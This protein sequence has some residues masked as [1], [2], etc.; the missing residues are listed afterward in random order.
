MKYSH[1]GWIHA[2]TIARVAD[3]LWW[4]GKSLATVNATE[5]IANLIFTYAGVYNTCYCDSNVFHWGLTHTFDLMTVTQTDI[6]ISKS[7]WIG[8]FI[9]GLTSCTFFVVYLV[10]ED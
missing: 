3:W 5:I 8:A 2:R 10:F 6:D 1:A 4:I 9:L 7:A